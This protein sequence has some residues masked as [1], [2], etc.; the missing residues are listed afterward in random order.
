MKF[1]MS[2]I[3]MSLALTAQARH[4]I[5]STKAMITPKSTVTAKAGNLM[6]YGG[7]VISNVRVAAVYWGGKVDSSVV[8]GSSKFYSAL[9]NSSQMDW[10]NQYNTHI[11]AMDGRAGTNQNIGK[12][13]FIGEFTITPKNISLDLQDADIQAE[14]EYQVSQNVLP[15]PDD[16][17]IFMI[18]FPPGINITIEGQK[19]CSTFCAYHEGFKSKTY[20][21]IFYGVMPDLGT[22]ACSFT[23][24]VGATTFESTT[25]VSAHELAEAVTDPFPTAGTQPGFPQAWNTTDGYEIGDLCQA[26]TTL[27][28]GGLTYTVT[29]LWDNSKGQCSDQAFQ[30]P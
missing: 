10:L 22:G 19:S 5:M 28:T 20:G 17:T 15:K 21:N 18:H 6:Y 14:I 25:F 7:S 26:A 9:V 12:G 4:G 13:S 29:K 30:A 16:N 1:M 27:L 2:L 3:V 11:K 8:Q 24:S 23:C